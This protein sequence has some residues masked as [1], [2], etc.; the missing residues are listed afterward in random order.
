MSEIFDEY[1]KIMTD[2][3][4]VKKADLLTQ[5]DKEN[6]SDYAETIK[7]LYGVDIKLNDS[8]KNI[9]EQAH[10][11]SVIIAPSYDRVNGLVE[12]INERHNIM[13]GIVNKPTNGNLTQHRYASQDLLDELI[14]L[15]F[16][17]DNA[18]EDSLSKTADEC[19]L[20]LAQDEEKKIKKNAFNWFNVIKAVPWL[21]TGLAAVFT[22]GGIKTNIIGRISQGIKPD[23]ENA[24]T[25][26][27]EL[28]ESV[29]AVNH[30]K[31]TGWIKG[32]LYIQNSSVRAEQILGN[33]DNQNITDITDESSAKSKIQGSAEEIEF[34]NEYAKM[35]KTVASR[36]GG[37]VV[38][39]SG[40]LSEIDNMQL[41][42][43]ETESDLWQSFEYIL[44]GAFGN[45]KTY[46]KNSLAALRNSL[47]AFCEAYNDLIQD[48][49]SKAKETE[50]SWLDW[51][52]GSEKDEE[53]SEFVREE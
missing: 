47:E 31:I 30:G 7:A 13:V 12:N 1:V 26:L 27:N 21:L 35:A 46:A 51:I 39:S 42:N 44:G 8:N 50:R 16:D 22:I 29:S 9:I 45:P 4:F 17:L 2:K 34:L 32:I 24:L 19:A 25:S 36:I 41:Q 6:D 28:K 37:G 10:P 49:T 53:I 23:A 18:G 15:G 20:L 48:G 33:S 5:H 3:G 52:N 43:K 14:R 38:S 40:I 11:E